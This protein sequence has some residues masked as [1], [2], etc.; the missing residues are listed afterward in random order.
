MPAKN[1]KK[2][3]LSLLLCC[4]LVMPLCTSCVGRGG[5]TIKEIDTVTV[6][7]NFSDSIRVSEPKTATERAIDAW[8]S[9][10]EKKNDVKLVIESPPDANY[11]ERL[12]I[13]LASGQYPD[14]IAFPEP[15]DATFISAI[16]KGKIISLNKY[17]E[18][19]PNIMKYT[20]DTSW[21]ALKSVGD[22]NIYA[23]P[24]STVMRADGYW[25]RKDWLANVGLSVPEDGVVSLSE[26]TEILKRFTENDPDGN[27]ERDT[28]GLGYYLNDEGYLE[29]PVSF[30]FGLLGWQKHSGKYACMDEKYCREH[31]HYENALAYAAELFH[32]GY[33]DPSC[34][35]VK[36]A[37]AVNRFYTGKVGV[38][39]GFSLHTAFALNIMKEYNPN[40]DITYI[41]AIKDQN[42][43][44]KGTMAGNGIYWAWGISSSAAKP[45][46]IVSMLDWILSDEGWETS[47]LG[48]EGYNYTI[49]EY[50]EKEP[51]R[52]DNG[53]R[54][55]VSTG[56]IFL[57]RANDV[58]IY[59]IPSETGEMMPAQ[60]LCEAW[61]Q[62]CVDNFVPG[63][64]AG[65]TPSVITERKFA[66]ANQELSLIIA[67]VISGELPVSSYSSQ[68][69]K[70]YAS[71]GDTYVQDMNQYIEKKGS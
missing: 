69:N 68:L 10:L 14:M 21:D 6:F 36:S 51:V 42:G 55:R 15:T 22:G 67:K 17:L 41:T 54:V 16:K 4:G 56:T 24:R 2:H 59:M 58:D 12:E 35:T 23:I 70:W 46:K 45:E 13:V 71:G 60:S 27:G 48:L 63:L 65:Y 52:A 5:D 30:P 26:F 39:P 44:T 57:R 62:H 40:A 31:H 18:H 29:P 25:V 64:D 28:Y 7:G 66:E 33:L 11:S 47:K 8:Y 53:R 61:L 50:G 20:L 32:N 34:F 9:L 19:A 38:L 3:I 43:D 49:N 1:K 37:A